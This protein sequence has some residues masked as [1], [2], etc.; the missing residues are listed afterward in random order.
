MSDPD[1][2]A[3]PSS[4]RT[5]VLAARPIGVAAL[6]AIPSL[7]PFTAALVSIWSFEAAMNMTKVSVA[8][9]QGIP[10]EVLLLIGSAAGIYIGGKTVEQFRKPPAPTPPE[11]QAGR[12]Q[13]SSVPEVAGGDPLSPPPPAA[14][15]EFDENAAPAVPENERDRLGTPV[16]PL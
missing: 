14:P 5:F 2:Q 11:E 3:L 4:V 12:A 6:I 13:P 9:L 16:L 7:G 15:V 1:L 10:G 8:F